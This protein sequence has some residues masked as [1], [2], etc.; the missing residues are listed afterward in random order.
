MKPRV[1]AVVA[2]CAILLAGT[3]ALSAAVYSHGD[4]TDS[5]QLLLELVN[6]ARANPHAEA[7][8]LGIGLND[9]ITAG[10]IEP[11]PKQPLALDAQLITAARAHSDW[12]LAADVF[13]HTGENGS[14]PEARMKAAGYKFTGNWTWG[15][16]VSWGGSTGIPD[17]IEYTRLAHDGLFKSPG[18]RVN[19]M[20]DDF[21]D[22][23]LGVREGKFFA[24]GRDWNAVM[25]TEVFARSGNTPGPVFLGVV[26][27]DANGDGL[28]DP[29]E[30]VGDV[31]VQVA[32]GTDSALTSGSGG[33]RL[34]YSG[35]GSVTLTF[36]HSSTG[37]KSVSTVRDGRNVKVDWIV[38]DGVE[39]GTLV[40]A[41]N[42]P[43]A[44]GL[45]QLQIGGTYQG[46]VRIERSTDF[47]GWEFAGII[48]KNSTTA[49]FTDSTGSRRHGFY[50]AS[51]VP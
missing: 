9:G 4:P 28:Y 25:T 2:G 1:A 33:Y 43:S 19:L 5:E 38:P 42:P 21:D 48:P 14:D 37:S 3:G 32:G 47:Q 35:S 46:N 26:Y 51:A 41:A 17:L 30:G 6:R 40:L 12:M 7:D 39:P 50:R 36:Q 31:T 44:A 18:H 11:T 34:P 20:N 8:R 49:L 15:E 22:V 27:R 10:S 45:V 29:G 23:G 16:N 24:Q 13:S